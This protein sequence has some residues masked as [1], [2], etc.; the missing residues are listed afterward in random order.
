MSAGAWVQHTDLQL[1]LLG[2]LGLQ[3]AGAPVTLPRSRKM[4]ALLAYLA[5]SPEPV[6]R[7]RL[8]DLLWQVPHDPRGEL[9]WY[10]SKIRGLLDT[11]ERARVITSAPDRVALDLS[12]CQ[13]DALEVDRS[14]RTGLESL[15][16]AQ[17][18]A[19]R[20]LFGGD[21]LD[22]LS[23]DASPQFDAWLS[24]QRHRFR[25]LHLALLELL[26]QR[27]PIGGD[28]AFQ[29]LESWLSLAPFDPRAHAALLSALVERGRL[30]DA[31][32]HLAR[33]IRAFEHEGVDWAPLREALRL[34]RAKPATP[35]RVI[36]AE[37]PPAPPVSSLPERRRAS[38]AVMPF[39]DTT[40]ASTERGRI[41]DWVTE[42]VITG[43]AK[44][45]VLFVVAR[46]TVYAL[47][48]RQIDPEEAGR[49][50]NVEYVVSGRVRQ[51]TSR[52]T[53]A[54]EIA[55]TR[56]SRIVWSDELQCETDAAY[57][58]VAT[59]IDRIVATIADEIEA[60]EC[61]RAVLKEPGSLDAWEAYHRGLW[62]MYKFNGQD[63]LEA[64]RFFRD[65]LERDPTFARAYAGL[66]FTHFQNAFLDLTADR[67]QQI[68]QAFATAADSVGADD[69]D[70]SAHWALG[71]ALWLR[72][73]QHESLAE[74][75]RSIELSPNFALGHYTLGFV[76][77]Q[78]GDPVAAIAATD[79]SRQLSPFDPLQFGMLAS[80]AIA[81]VRIGQLDEAAAWAVRAA[82]RPN[83]HVHILAIAVECLVLAN[84]L[85]EA[86]ALVVRARSRV[87]GYG[88][89]HLLRAFRFASETEQLFRRC[90]RQIG[91]D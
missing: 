60:A 55:D 34:A 83:A 26:V 69:R 9:R 79:H 70:P 10:L 89:E 31:D 81:H 86:R 40:P 62:H 59:T 75:Q 14:A 32:E 20:Q 58:I 57:A 87:P 85:D 50:L 13:V 12:D 44:L 47:R 90:A 17:L 52:L 30:R 48:D 78:S 51:Q 65:A 41:G 91:F 88:V 22:G 82:A 68:D 45:R 64:Q 37:S 36:L 74:L 25:G 53:I 46:G 38:V 71:R 5:L 29:C 76:Q 18:S 7:S 73:E 19:L 3:R 72:G 21:L 15:S 35:A 6:G 27:A 39:V 56:T 16:W 67:A 63:N 23:L 77:C 84:R 2:P 28:D 1:R 8:C 42:D 43:L 33:S 54:L 49:I 4:R 11:P 24:A 80:R 66:S 61:Q